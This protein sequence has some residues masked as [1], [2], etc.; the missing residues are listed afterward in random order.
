MDDRGQQPAPDEAPER[1]D[2][3]VTPGVAAATAAA[4]SDSEDL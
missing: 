1:H 2:A 4:P 3:T